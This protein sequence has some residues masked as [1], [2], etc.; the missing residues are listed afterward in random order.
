MGKCTI[1]HNWLSDE[2]YS[3]VNKSNIQ[4]LKSYLKL[5]L[6]DAMVSST[7]VEL[8]KNCKKTLAACFKYEKVEEEFQYLD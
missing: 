7:K 4:Q 2:N 5:L 1:N 3:R 6:K 8:S